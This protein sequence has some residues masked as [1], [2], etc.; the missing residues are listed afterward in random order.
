MR[1]ALILA[2]ILTPTLPACGLFV[3]APPIVTTQRAGCS[4]L[5]PADWAQGT[6]AAEIPTGI[7][8]G[9]ASV[10][11]WQVLADREAA[12]GDT[13][14]DRTRA[15]VHIVTA[16]EARDAEAIRRATRRRFLGVF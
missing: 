6:P 9:E 15:T 12:R 10:G 5:I 8:S 4:S 7:I 16:C 14:D 11:D 3:D 2:S 13:A 1:K